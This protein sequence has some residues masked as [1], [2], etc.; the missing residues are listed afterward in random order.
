MAIPPVN[1]P[2]GGILREWPALPREFARVVFSQERHTSGL[3][4]QSLVN[5][6][7]HGLFVVLDAS[8][9]KEMLG[10]NF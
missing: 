8:T 5:G 6:L 3:L 7:A 2:P 4:Y 1:I 10:K 9:L